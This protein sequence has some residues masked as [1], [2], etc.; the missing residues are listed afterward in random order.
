MRP[1][2]SREMPLGMLV[3]YFLPPQS[4]H[5][6]P[7]GHF[8]GHEMPQGMLGCHFLPPETA[9][10]MLVPCFRSPE[11]AHNASR[12]AFAGKFLPRDGQ[13]LPGAASSSGVGGVRTTGIKIF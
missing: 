2:R 9:H 3:G 13:L 1:F 7:V 11:M 6:M 4:A 5:G 8:R 10:G 12:A